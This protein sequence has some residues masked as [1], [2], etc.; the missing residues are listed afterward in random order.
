[1]RKKWIGMSEEE[2]QMFLEEREKFLKSQK[3]LR[4]MGIFIL[5]GIGIL[6]G[7]AIMNGFYH[8]L[9]L[10]WLCGVIFLFFSW[11]TYRGIALSIK[12]KEYFFTALL[13]IVTGYDIYM[14]IDNFGFI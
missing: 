5:I 6:V 12:H 8:I 14:A 3:R 11:V 1:M 4:I 2:Y 10:D 7:S 9:W 13:I